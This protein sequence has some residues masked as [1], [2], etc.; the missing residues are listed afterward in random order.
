MDFE[1]YQAEAWRYDQHPDEPE[2]A[3]TVALLGL[4][5]EVGS[6]QTNQKKIVRDGAIYIDSRSLMIEDLGDVL[7][8]IAD[9]ASWLGVSLDEIAK[10]NLEKIRA[11][12]ASH[13]R[14]MPYGTAPVP[15]LPEPGRH[16][17]LG[18][19]HLFDGAHPNRDER[20]PRRLEV[21][22]A[23]V[24]ITVTPDVSPRVLPVWGERPCG[25]ILGDNS[26]DDD[27]YRYHDA[28]HL[29]YLA[30]LGWSPVFRALLGRKRKATPLID[31][32]EDGGRSIA[33]EEGL[34][35]FIFE[36]ASRAGYFEGA[37]CV[38]GDIL[39]LCR[40]MTANLE[41]R[42]CADLEWERTILEGFSVWRLVRSYGHAA[43]CCDLDA[44]TISARPLTK[45]ER[46]HH[47]E[48]CRKTAKAESAQ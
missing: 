19:A 15:L 29:A 2:R 17:G 40:R 25:N 11:R 4:G 27:G 16:G 44:R 9:T 35:A 12:W 32:V 48:I 24:P 33:I 26:Y 31:D 39:R 42:K 18:P 7:W 8:Y 36:A 20:L 30:I 14:P 45:S 34:S 46:A 47:A 43:I 41:V 5:G 28:F 38:D 37:E 21:H 22:L 13:S 23:T 1:T 3:L 10:A 6:L